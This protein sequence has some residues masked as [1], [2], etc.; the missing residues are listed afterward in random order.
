MIL[1]DLLVPSDTG[2][3]RYAKVVALSTTMDRFAIVGPDSKRRS[4]EVW[5]CSSQV[6]SDDFLVAFSQFLE[7]DVSVSTPAES[8]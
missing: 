7:L 5:S 8:V 4:V 1:D 2:C 3:S 6:K